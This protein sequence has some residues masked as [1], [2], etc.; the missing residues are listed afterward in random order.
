MILDVSPKALKVGYVKNLFDKI[1]KVYNSYKSN[2]YF[3]VFNE[4]F[5]NR[6]IIEFSDFE[7]YL[8]HVCA[9]TKTMPKA[10]FWVNFLHEVQN[11]QWNYDTMKTYDDGISSEVFFENSE[12]KNVVVKSCPENKLVVAK[13]TKKTFANESFGI[14][15]GLVVA[16]YKKST[17]YNEC[18]DV[19]SSIHE[20]LQDAISYYYGFGIDEKVEGQEQE[21]N[22]VANVLH[23]FVYTDICFDVKQRVRYCRDII[24]RRNFDADSSGVK[25]MVDKMKSVY[26]NEILDLSRCRLHIIQS[27]SVELCPM[28]LYDGQVLVYSDTKAFSVCLIKYS[29]RLRSSLASLTN[30]MCKNINGSNANENGIVEFNGRKMYDWGVAHGLKHSFN[31]SELNQSA[32]LEID[33]LIKKNLFAMVHKFNMDETFVEIDD[34]SICVAVSEEISL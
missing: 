15:N 9:L 31:K 5:F 1:K 23:D 11:E 33:D 19:L 7:N 3:I 14:Y 28:D 12:F 29:E 30:I 18:D 10:I 32:M 13:D 6:K 17:Y 25:N 34:I 24:L 4:Y 20:Q 22:D 16:K 27:A 2:F 8:N 21:H 26:G